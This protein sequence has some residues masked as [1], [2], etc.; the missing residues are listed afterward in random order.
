MTERTERSTGIGISVLD[1]AAIVIGAAVAAV[2]LRGILGI[3]D[4]VGPSWILLSI[5]FAWVTLTAAGPFVYL[6]RRCARTIPEYPR[7]GDRLWAMLGLPWLVT[8][9]LRTSPDAPPDLA[10]TTLG[11]GLLI[12]SLIA[13][14]T[15]W[16]TWV[17]VSPERAGSTFS[18]PWTNRVGLFLAIAW[19]IQCG[20]GMV[21]MELS[22]SYTEPRFG[23]PGV[24]A[25]P[26]GNCDWDS[27][28]ATSQRG[29][30]RFDVA[31]LVVGYSLASMLIRAYWPS[32][33]SLS[34]AEA[35]VISLVFLWLGLAMSGPAVLLV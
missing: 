4:A 24:R 30:H 35:A 7:V 2:H 25:G 27:S 14:F 12:A 15:V 17:M 23:S 18:G 26:A 1:G 31:A 21:V 6:P 28:V 22:W 16:T 13:L 34:I 29:F 3:D 5:T 33:G 32:P 20:A 10:Q 11:L 19:P 8:A 9:I